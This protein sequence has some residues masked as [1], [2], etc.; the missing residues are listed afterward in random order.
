MKPVPILP[1]RSALYLPASN[2]RAIEKARGLSADMIILDLEDAV[3]P[4][5]K[6][7]ARDAAVA[8]TAEGFGERIVAIRIN[9]SG[10][11]WYDADVAAVR[12]SAADFVVVPKVEDAAV[13]AALASKLGKPVLAM[14]ETPLAILDA[15]AIARA[16]GVAGLIT[17]TNDLATELRLP[18]HSGRVSM[19]VALQMIVL[20]ARAAGVWALDGVF[21][22]LEDPA[23]LAAECA[24]GRGLGFD[25]KTLIHPN[26]IE[27][28]NLAWSPTPAERAEA[29]ALIAA[30][31]GGAERYQG[32]MI[33]TMHVDAARRLL[34]RT[35]A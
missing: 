31:K 30:A 1:P 20:S 29:E 34:A 9:A 23:G 10:S 24:E 14:V 25:G 7:L 19:A 6:L 15:P 35:Q 3:K 4:E 17:G 5:D 27:A 16:T 33:E 21:N 32:R 26:Q 11:D 28:T 22:G 13:I 12:A 18:P 2:A 8:A